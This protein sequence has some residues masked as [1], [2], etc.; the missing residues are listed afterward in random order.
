MH[1]LLLTLVTCSPLVLSAC[2]REAPPASWLQASP[3]EPGSDAAGTTPGKP[4]PPAPPF[5]SCEK[6]PVN[7]LI[8]VDQFGYRPAAKKVAVLVDPVEGW[9]ADDQLTPG[10]TY[11]VRSWADGKLMLS[12][13]PKPW[14]Q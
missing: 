12:G 3:T 11:E 5:V 10:S 6:T 8:R 14:N 9:N 1:R 13:A 7:E 4:R 2:A